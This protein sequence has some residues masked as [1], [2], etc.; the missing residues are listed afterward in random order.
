MIDRPSSNEFAHYYHK[1]IQE[2]PDGNIIE[3][4]EQQK[5]N[6]EKF[7][8]SINE[9]KSLFRYAEGKWSIREVLG[10]IIDAERIFSYRALRFSRKDPQP[11]LS[12]EEN[13][14]VSNSNYNSILLM[15]ICEEFSSLRKSNILMFKGFKE[16][17]W[18]MTGIASE[19]NVS[20]R[21]IAYI[22]AGH[23]NHHMNI[24]K[25]RYL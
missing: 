5:L 18:T 13:T 10:H 7:F 25:E 9:E 20:V 12:F 8:S 16:K 22:M 2:V 1:S 6:A 23:F 3:I 19:N 15:N 11:L 24:I 17:M 21:A 14:Y 4:L